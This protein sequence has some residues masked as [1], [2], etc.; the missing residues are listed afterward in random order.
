LAR[1]EF[2]DFLASRPAK[3]PLALAPGGSALRNV[4]IGKTKRV[5]FRS[6]FDGLRP[7]YD[8]FGRFSGAFDPLFAS[9][10]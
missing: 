2:A 10:V 1:A 8:T 4:K 6:F 7:N 5:I 9:D 3:S